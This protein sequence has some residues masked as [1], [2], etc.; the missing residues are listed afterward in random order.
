MSKTDKA[1]KPGSGILIGIAGA[2]GSGKTLVAQTLVDSL[3]SEKVLCLQEDAYYKDLSHLP[4]EERTR[5]NFD[6]PEAFDHD[7][8]VAHLKM[9]LTGQAI[10]HPIYDYATHSRRPE[11][12]RVE[13]RPIIIL[14]GILVLA[15]PELRALMDIKIFIDTPPDICFIR[16]LER[17][18]R[19]RGRTVDS[20]I[21]QYK[22]TVRPMYLQF[23]EPSKRYAD[24]IIPRGGKNVIAI[25]IVRSKIQHL[26]EGKHDPEVFNPQT[27]GEE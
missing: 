10:E 4:F 17:D 3:G 24:I 5:F 21:A 12:R 2:S 14:E 7:L 20:V 27:A 8:L 15:V 11:T 6:H 16:R 9:L 22:S 26:L 19:E 18:I 13:P 1:S 25:D 23:I